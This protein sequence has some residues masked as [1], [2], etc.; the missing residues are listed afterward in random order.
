MILLY[1]KIKRRPL[2]KGVPLCWELSRLLVT[3]TRREANISRSLALL[4]GGA[5]GGTSLLTCNFWLMLMR[6]ITGSF[7][8]V[9]RYTYNQ[10]KTV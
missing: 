4:R 9:S 10:S 1:L 5:S 8:Y 3:I 6:L 2:I 7:C